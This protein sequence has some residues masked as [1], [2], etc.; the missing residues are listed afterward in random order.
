MKKKNS[1]DELTKLKKKLARLEKK[2][3]KAEGK[4]LVQA[5]IMKSAE[6]TIKKIDKLTKS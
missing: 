1:G 3:D 5:R 2:Y 4:K 6:A